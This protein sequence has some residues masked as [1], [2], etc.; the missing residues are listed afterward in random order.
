MGVDGVLGMGFMT[1][2][3]NVSLVS[4]FPQT[5]ISMNAMLFL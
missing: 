1:I 2:S 3:D 4:M 5:F